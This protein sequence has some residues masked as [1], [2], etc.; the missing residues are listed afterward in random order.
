MDNRKFIQYDRFMGHWAAYARGGRSFPGLYT[1]QKWPSG[2]PTSRERRLN[3]KVVHTYCQPWEKAR[4]RLTREL[5]TQPHS[6]RERPTSRVLLCKTD[7][8][9]EHADKAISKFNED[10]KR[11]V[12][13]AWLRG[14]METRDICTVLGISSREVRNYKVRVFNSLDIVL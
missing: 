5:I 12:L 4:N 1:V 2:R 3:G 14:K 9:I 8:Q 11:F 6:T 7:L 10:M 13:V